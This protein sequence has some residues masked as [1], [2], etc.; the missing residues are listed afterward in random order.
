[1]LTNKQ[2]TAELV[3]RAPAK[4]CAFI[5]PGGE[6]A[7]PALNAI[8][9]DAASDTGVATPTPPITAVTGADV[10]MPTTHSNPQRKHN[11]THI[12]AEH[13]WGS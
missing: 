13:W 12:D 3:K 4:Q 1:M 10:S 2:C 7:E 11:N 8:A 6:A 9:G 5:I